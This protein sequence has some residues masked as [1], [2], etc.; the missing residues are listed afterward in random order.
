[1]KYT[2]LL[3]VKVSKVGFGTPRPFMKGANDE[4]IRALATKAFDL[5]INFF[6][7]APAYQTEH[8]F[9]HLPRDQVYLSTKSPRKLSIR[10]GWSTVPGRLEKALE[11]SLK[12]LNTDYIDF[13]FLHSITPNILGKIDI[14]PGIWET[15][16]NFKKQGKVRF[17][18]ISED[19]TVDKHHV[20]TNMIHKYPMIDLMMV[21]ANQNPLLRRSSFFTPKE[22][23][24]VGMCVGGP[25]N[26]ECLDRFAV[27]L[28]GTTN[29]EHLIQ[30]AGIV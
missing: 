3:G 10:A 25:I 7:T 20:V 5:G 16:T 26:K 9:N 11:A 14:T 27:T 28:T 29:A 6:D 8:T 17:I 23:P 4:A 13:Y 30:N 2:E 1:M 21:A 19:Q 24:Y 22:V 12:A 18:G 15:V